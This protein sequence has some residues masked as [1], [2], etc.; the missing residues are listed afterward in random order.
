MED[1]TGSRSDSANG[2]AGSGTSGV[3]IN[4]SQIQ[5]VGLFV[6]R[7][8]LS[9]PY[10]IGLSRTLHPFFSGCLSPTSCLLYGERND[11]SDKT[12]LTLPFY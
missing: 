5:L 6:R 3:F 11:F 9:L 12:Y 8:S 4:S 2:A 1:R 10:T 7:V